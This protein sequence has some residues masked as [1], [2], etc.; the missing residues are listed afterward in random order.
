MDQ[1]APN[2]AIILRKNNPKTTQKKSIRQLPL[3]GNQFA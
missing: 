3:C 2:Q 1:V